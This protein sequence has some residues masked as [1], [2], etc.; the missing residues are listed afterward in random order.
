MM[1]SFIKVIN[2]RKKFQRNKRKNIY[3]YKEITQVT[4]Y[5]GK[6]IIEAIKAD[7]KYKK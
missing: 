7:T 6:E 1:V 3:I 5:F 2:N 4:L